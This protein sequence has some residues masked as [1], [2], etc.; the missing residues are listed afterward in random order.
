MGRSPGRNHAQEITGGNGVGIGAAYSCL[1]LPAEGVY[2]AGSH[3]TVAAADTEQAKPAL[4]LLL[5]E[6]LPGGVYILGRCLVEH[7]YAGQIDTFF[8]T[9]SPF[10]Q[11]V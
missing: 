2:P 10:L 1:R 9:I 7:L 5:I 8:H 6:P 3:I 4:G 11:S